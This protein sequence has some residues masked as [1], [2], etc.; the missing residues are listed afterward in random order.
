MTLTGIEKLSRA[1]VQMYSKSPF[2]AYLALNLD[3]REFTKEEKKVMGERC[4]M[5][6]DGF[7]NLYWN[8]DFVNDLKESELI[9]VVAHECMHVALQ[10]LDRENKRE[11]E[12]WNIAIDIS[13][14]N[15]LLNNGFALPQKGIIP[16]N[17]SITFRDEKGRDLVT[18]DG[19]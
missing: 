18:I 13:T 14:N 3:F 2:F 9:G 19:I 10:H 7:G 6:V 11:H 16:V 8:E 4:T 15:L 1:R 12:L 5:A 17:N